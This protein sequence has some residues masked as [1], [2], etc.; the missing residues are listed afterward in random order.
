MPEYDYRCEKCKHEF[1]VELS[2][3]ERGRK[4][5]KGEIRCPKCQSAKVRHQIQS[6]FV[7]TSRKS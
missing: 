4:E 3:T 1:T 6:V 7:T 5:E 2:I